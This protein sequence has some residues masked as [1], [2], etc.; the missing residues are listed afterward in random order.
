MNIL[1][2]FDGCSCGQQALRRAGVPYERYFA[3][4][5]DPRAIAV[6][7][8]NFPDTIQTGSVTE[9]VVDHPAPID[10][11]MG[12]SPCQ[13]FSMAGKRRGMAT[14]EKEEVTSLER[15]LQLKSEGFAFE[16]QSY[17]FWEYVRL[18]RGLQPKY[19]LLENV[20]M[21]AR[22]EALI[23][24]TLG[25]EPIRL[26]SRLLSAQNRERLYWTNIPYAGDPEDKGLL[27]KDV[28]EDGA[29]LVEP[30]RFALTEKSHAIPAT[31]HKENEK[32]MCR[33]RKFGLVSVCA[34]KCHGTY[35][36]RPDGKA[37]CVDANYAKGA[38][39]HGQRT[40][41]AT[42]VT[43]SFE[44]GHAHLNGHDFLKRVYSPEGK[45]PTLTA[46]CGGNQ[47]RKVACGAVVYEG[48][49]N[50]SEFKTAF[51]HVKNAT[52]QVWLSGVIGEGNCKWTPLSDLTEA[53]APA[54]LHTWRKLT[55]LE[56]E[57]LQT[58]EDGYTAQ[59]LVRAY[60]EARPDVWPHVRKLFG[61]TKQIFAPSASARYHMVGNGWTVD[62]IAHLLRGI[63]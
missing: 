22:W 7:Q 33:R 52:A 31:I 61:R 44:V 15:Y 39:N 4:E 17:L 6:T 59:P 47:E 10:L 58:M 20:R 26:N 37:T 51:A 5:I 50:L 30:A 40:L 32:S 23:T 43:Q 24:E 2:L 25:V 11:L 56:C 19:F 53:D 63:R 34:V 48:Q 36:P 21:P 46:V 41:V 13:D 45:G 60:A 27:L 12:G 8:A 16:G 1:S 29:D 38:D 62:V 35:V 49:G 9:L 28:L 57:R 42:P 55:P 14:K 18:L 3:S 54:V